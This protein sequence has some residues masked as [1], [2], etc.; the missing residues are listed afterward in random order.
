MALQADAHALR[1]H[2]RL[3]Q[4]DVS[5]LDETAQLS[6][7]LNAL[8]LLQSVLNRTPEMNQTFRCL[9][10]R[11]LN[12]SSVLTDSTDVCVTL[13]PGCSLTISYFLLHIFL[14]HF[15]HCKVPR[16]SVV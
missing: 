4:E 2:V 7:R 6:S 13:L 12:L 3:E 9:E 10:L 14:S 8:H 16:N 1:L 11:K 5:L 15:T